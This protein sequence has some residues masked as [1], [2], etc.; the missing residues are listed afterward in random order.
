MTDIKNLPKEL[1]AYM[2]RKVDKLIKEKVTV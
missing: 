1:V 2:S